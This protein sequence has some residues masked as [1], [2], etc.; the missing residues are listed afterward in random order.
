MQEE[1]ML[2]FDLVF[3]QSLSLI[4]WN[5]IQINETW[6]AISA[7]KGSRQGIIWELVL[8]NIEFV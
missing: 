5:E 3:L 4:G 6:I 2:P 1:K 8:K 7:V